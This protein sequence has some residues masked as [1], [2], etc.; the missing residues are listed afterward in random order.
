MAARASWAVLA[1]YKTATWLVLALWPQWGQDLVRLMVLA[2]ISRPQLGH[3]TTRYTAFSPIVV[4][5]QGAV[6]YTHLT[7]PT[8]PYV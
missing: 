1:L 4:G 2:I 8:T 3:L 7:L 5:F 6:S